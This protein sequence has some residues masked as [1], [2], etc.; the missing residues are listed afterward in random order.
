MEQLV[1][2]V[3]EA[4]GELLKAIKSGKMEASLL[5]VDIESLEARKAQAY[6]DLEKIQ[7]QAEKAKSKMDTECMTIHNEA[8]AKL[9]RANAQLKEADVKMAEA[10]KMEA[11][12]SEAWES[13]KEQEAK[14][15]K[16]RQ[17]YEDK[18]SKLKAAGVV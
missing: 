5:Q 3:Q 17:T 1:E 6:K 12:A 16:L 10:S 13:A 11:K 8:T 14:A 2:K 4:V 9:A 18:L 15:D 7:A